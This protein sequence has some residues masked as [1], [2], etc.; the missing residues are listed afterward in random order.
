M[1]KSIKRKS[2][3]FDAQAR[4]KELDRMSEKTTDVKEETT[5]VRKSPKRVVMT[6]SAKERRIRVIARYE[7]QLENGYTDIGG[8][9]RMP[10][11]ADKIRIQNEIAILR[12]RI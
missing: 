12:T 5:F 7:N 10:T 8:V 2:S 3:E 11:E 6:R 4:I 1:S 9:L